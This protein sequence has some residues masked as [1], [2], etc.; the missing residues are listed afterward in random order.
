MEQLDKLARQLILEGL[1]RDDIAI[2][3][4]WLDNED[5][6]LVR[7]LLT[8]AQRVLDEAQVV[9]LTAED[10]LQNA[11][12]G[13]GAKGKPCLNMFIEAG[14]ATPLK[15]FNTHPA[16]QGHPSAPLGKWFLRRAKTEAKTGRDRRNTDI[17]EQNPRMPYYA[18]ATQ[19]LLA[20]TA[21]GREVSDF[22]KSCNHRSAPE[23]FPESTLCR[24]DRE[25]RSQDELAVKYGVHWTTVSRWYRLLW[26]KAEDTLPQNL[27]DSLEY[28]YENYLNS[29]VG[30]PA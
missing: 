6:G 3:P 24:G 11:L 2:H 29:G 1:G 5:S 20:G 15:T 7:E 27:K 25:Y 4:A 13:L 28:A 12:V 23:D 17:P 10:L 8:Y 9:C 18:F 21:L 16:L 30:F 14:K 26:H 22:I 19:H